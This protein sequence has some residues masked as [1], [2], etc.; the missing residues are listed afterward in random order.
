M[1]FNKAHFLLFYLTMTAAIAS[2]LAIFS[3]ASTITVLLR[4]AASGLF[5]P[6][7]LS[8]IAAFLLDP[9]VNSLEKTSHS[10][11]QSNL[12]RFFYDISNAAAAR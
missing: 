1:S 4:S 5:V 11:H 2:G 7:L 10:A 12:Q 6:L 8:V 3:S 9:L